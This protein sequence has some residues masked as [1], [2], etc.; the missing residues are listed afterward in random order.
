MSDKIVRGLAYN[1][2][3]NVKC[4]DTTELV[5]E[6]RKIHDLSPV[7]TAA[8]GRLLTMGCIMGSGLKEDNDTIT[9]Q[10]KADGPLGALNAVVNS[11]ME[12]KGYVQNPNVDLPLKDNGKLDVGTAVGKYGML[13]IIKDIGLKEPYIGLT[14]LISGEIAEDFAEYFAKSEQT[15]SAIALGVLVNKNGVKSAGGYM[16]TPMPDATDEDISKLEE[17]LKNKNYEFDDYINKYDTVENGE[18]ITMGKG[19]KGLGA[20]KTSFKQGNDYGGVGKKKVKCI[21]TGVVYDSIAECSKELNLNR[22]KISDVC[23]KRRKSTGNS[24]TAYR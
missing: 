15:P 7:A 16:I 17:N 18:N 6:A 12:I 14:P 8:L 10:I 9:L 19:R 20:N 5:E 23:N 4:I 2:K 1:G 21:E 24:K 11:N 3:V 13:Y 22:N